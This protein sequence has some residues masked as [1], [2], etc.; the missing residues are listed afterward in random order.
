MVVSGFNMDADEIRTGAGEGFDITM[1][2]GKH[3][4]GVEKELGSAAAQGCES[5]G[6]EGQVGDEVP[7]HDVDV[8]PVESK[9]GDGRYAGGQVGVVTGQQRWGENRSVGH[10]PD[11]KRRQVKGARRQHC[12][13]PPLPAYQTSRTTCTTFSAKASASRG[14]V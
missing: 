14:K 13:C 11:R 6:A 9:L 2:L 10:G 8:E 5:F 1:R 3:Q 4:V 7:V 12:W